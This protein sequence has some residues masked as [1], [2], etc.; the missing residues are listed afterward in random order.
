MENDP[1]S[2]LFYIERVGFLNT[3]GGAN[4]DVRVKEG[5]NGKYV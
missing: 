4:F 3:M 2:I 1:Q 5:I